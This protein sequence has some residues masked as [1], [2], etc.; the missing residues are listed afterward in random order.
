[1]NNYKLF[2]NIIGWLIFLVAAF[3]FT[4]TREPTVSL[5]DCGEF[6]SG[7]FKLQ[8]VHAPGAPFFLMLGRLFTLLAGGDLLKVA[9][10]VNLLS[11]LASA[12]SILFLF[13]SI[14]ALSKK[15][16]VNEEN[17]LN[18]ERKLAIFGSAIIGSLVCT[19]SD[20]FWFSAVEG[21]VYA[22]SSFFTA[23]VFW[24]IL[25]WE[26]IADERYADRWLVFI[27][28]MMG[29]SI[30]VHLLNLLAIPAL[31][32]VYY[33][34]KYSPTRK[35]TFI[36]FVISCFILVF[37]LWGVIP[38]LPLL[39]SKFELV[40][41]NWFSLPF[42]SGVLIMSILLISGIIFGIVY[43]IKKQN[44][45]LNT[46]FMCLTMIIIGYSSYAVV[47]IRSNAGPAINMSDPSDV[48]TFLSYLNREQYGDWPLV[49]GQY[50]TA[51]LTEIKEGKTKYYQ[52]EEEY[53]ELGKDIIPV[54]DPKHT[55]FFPRAWS[56]QRKEHAKFYREW[57]GLEKGKKPSFAQNLKFYF[58]Y[59]LGYIY[60]RYFMW[61]FSGR[62][63][64]IQGRWEPTKEGS[65]ITGIPAIDEGVIGLPK[66]TNLPASIGDN[67][68]RNKYYMLPFILGIIGLVFHFQ[69]KK[70]DAFVVLLLFAMTGIMINTY[71][72][73]TP[74]QPRERDYT[75]VGSYYTYC[76]WIG[77]G[78]IAIYEYLRKY[79]KGIGAPIIATLLCIPI[80]YMMAQQNWDDHD[81]S[82]RYAGRKLAI[83]YLE[84]CPP[85]AILFTQGDNDTYPLWYAQEVENIRP[86]VRTVNLSLLGVDW[87]I[88]FL[89]RK[90][91]DAD[92][93]PISI[94]SELYRG[95]KL[96]IVQYVDVKKFDQKRY[97]DLK[98]VVAFITTDDKKFKQQT[99]RGDFVNYMPVKNFSIPVD[100]EKI[101]ASGM[102]S[103][104]NENRI[105]D[106]VKFRINKTNFYKPDVIIL[107]LLSNNNWERPICFATSVASSNYL[108]LSKYF[109][110]EGLIYR[111]VPVEAKSKDR[112]GLPE[113]IFAERMYENVVNKYE[114]IDSTTKHIYLNDD[115]QRNIMNIR[116]SIA[117][118]AA[119]LIKNGENE[120]A[121]EVID[122]CVNGIPEKFVPYYGPY[123]FIMLRYISL[124]YR[125]NAV[126]KAQNI[127]RKIV[128]YC[129][130][131]ILY[132]VSL[133]NENRK[134]YYKE[135]EQAYLTIQELL[136]YA[137]L[138]KDQEMVDE[139]TPIAEN[140]QILLGK[141]Q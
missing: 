57:M 122:L 75:Y 25:K 58:G 130:E 77:I 60:G 92:P 107:D 37:I 81:R 18:L 15:L 9:S 46:A 93:V 99:T 42:G 66:Q 23:L 100:R 26:S 4:S 55:G 6:I 68:G 70:K 102:V 126:D 39:A 19:F 105:V 40:F 135:Q 104:K 73:P 22:L 80:P 82:T 54:Y 59:Q 63:N 118:L 137:K 133:S 24:S 140:M 74:L 119:E 17:G 71:L 38:L 47:L 72:N 115:N 3:V 132:Y 51:K 111:I 127:L 27:A 32:I 120:K 123:S 129:H 11:A 33:F 64:D 112:D 117:R 136:R 141:A 78:M 13:W 35:G 83:N 7:A 45:L 76:I 106:K 98:K 50:F 86:D 8:I 114:W 34:K 101:I 121:E 2:N 124:Y 48:F 97:Y 138:N 91:N 49:H 125:L 79:F 109:Q 103:K 30:G 5:W 52:G 94:P 88:D 31:G 61:N 84:S 21:E 56:N 53:E 20:T 43:S 108:G 10:M 29:L 67:K 69:R 113:G 41:I 28:Y 96:N 131:N 110:Q 85:N 1:M 90:I 128:Y 89:K 44:A 134:L 116:N 62:Q 87:Y 12:F 16:F 95:D 139:V 14:T 65:F 36:A